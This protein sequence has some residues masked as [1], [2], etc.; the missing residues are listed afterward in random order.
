MLSERA[1]LQKACDTWLKAKHREKSAAQ[2][3]REIEDWL[4]AQAGFTKPFEGPKHIT[5]PGYK[6]KVEGRINRKVDA[7]KAEELAHEND[8][9]CYLDRLFTWKAEISI[10]GWRAT[11]KEITN[12][13]APAITVLPGR[14][15]FSIEEEKA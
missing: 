1:K 14:P 7:A 5:I 3:R 9:A 13:F 12:V 15:S 4:L 8:L 6:L 10:K 11:G 2:E